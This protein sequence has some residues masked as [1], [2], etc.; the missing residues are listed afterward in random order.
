MKRKRGGREISKGKYCSFCEMKSQI[1]FK[2]LARNPTGFRRWVVHMSNKHFF[3]S[4]SIWR[5]IKN[6]NL[7]IKEK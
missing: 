5:R 7:L 3:F 1:L 6:R 4:F 2:E